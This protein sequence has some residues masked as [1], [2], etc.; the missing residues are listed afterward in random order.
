MEEHGGVG[1]KRW[2]MEIEHVEWRCDC[3]IRIG[4]PFYFESRGQEYPLKA[5][6][7]QH[8]DEHGEEMLIR[9]SSEL[10]VV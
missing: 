7:E 10:V 2:S 6:V 5:P 9:E 8:E 1:A 4:D 3:C